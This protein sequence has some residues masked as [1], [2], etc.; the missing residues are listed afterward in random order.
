M[1]A[2]TSFSTKKLFDSL[3]RIQFMCWPKAYFV[4]HECLRNQ[5]NAIAELNDQSSFMKILDTFRFVWKDR[6]TCVGCKIEN[7]T[8]TVNDI[9]NLFVHSQQ[10]IMVPS[11][12]FK[13]YARA[14]FP[15]IY[16]HEKR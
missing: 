5:N 3:V 8:L 10:K 14:K 6:F 2:I 11:V 12:D 13:V 9:C 4:D 15:Y 16:V 1:K 7:T